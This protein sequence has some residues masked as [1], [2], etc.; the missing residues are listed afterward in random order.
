[1]RLTYKEMENRNTRM[2]FLNKI[3]QQTRSVTEHNISF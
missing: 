2:T 1:M 3:G